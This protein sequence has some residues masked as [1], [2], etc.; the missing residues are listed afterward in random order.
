MKLD[1]YA[2]LAWAALL[3]TLV[4]IVWGAYVRA[5]GSGAGCGKNWPLCKGGVWSVETLIELT[6]RATSGLAL[7]LTVAMLVFAFRN[8]PRG[9]RVRRGATLSMIFMIT[10]ALVGAG[11]VLFELVA[12]DA[13]VARALFMSVHLVNTFILLGVMTLTAWWASGGPPL[14]LRRQGALLWLF[15]ASILG[16][17]ILGVSGAIAALGDTLFPAASFAEGMSQDFSP[18][19]HLLLRLRVLHPTLALTVGLVLII[20]GFA[21]RQARPQVATVRFATA[22]QALIFIQIVAGL[23]NVLLLTPIWLQLVHLV[24]ADLTWIALV[25]T[26]GSALSSAP[27]SSGVEVSM[28]RSARPA[29]A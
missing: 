6:H 5:S 13:S 15:L 22:L 25:L 24:L 10:E 26:A 19:A 27:E 2:K 28:S 20:A 7:V 23:V 18:T 3:F 4:V 14:R 1:R 8:Y 9:H 16:T 12:H 17:L 29:N 21:A 11:L